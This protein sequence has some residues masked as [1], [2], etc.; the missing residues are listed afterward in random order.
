MRW[1]VIALMFAFSSPAFAAVHLG[2][3]LSSAMS[4]RPILGLDLGVGGES[5]R[6]TFSSIG[7]NSNIYYHSSYTAALFRSWKSGSL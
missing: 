2:A 6:A 1:T 5:W 7:T 4:G 3:G